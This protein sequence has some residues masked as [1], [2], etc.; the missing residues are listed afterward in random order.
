MKVRTTKDYENEFI[1]IPTGPG[2]HGE[3]MIRGKGPKVCLIAS[4]VRYYGKK[5]EELQEYWMVS[6]TLDEVQAALDFAEEY[7]HLIDWERYAP[8]EDDD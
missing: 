4:Y 3:P 7:P 1:E 6:L 8:E 5:P 2:K